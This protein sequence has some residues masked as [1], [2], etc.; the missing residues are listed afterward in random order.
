MEEQEQDSLSEAR[1]RVSFLSEWV[2]G[3]LEGLNSVE[4]G[5][6]PN[7][8]AKCGERC[9]RSWIAT[10]G[11]DK[12]CFTLDTLI[13]KFNEMPG[14]VWKK[15]GNTIYEELSF[16]KCICPMVTWGIIEPNSKLC[17]GCTRN[18]HK[19]L[20]REVAGLSVEKS[21]LIDSVALGGDKCIFRH[22]LR[23][24]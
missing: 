3:V 21:E 17:L 24:E 23:L 8:L 15:E 13:S 1:A 22:H 20:F 12:Q 6:L 19:T 5:K 4:E 10:A 7:V 16:G 11:L 14:I 9:M 2:K 18:F